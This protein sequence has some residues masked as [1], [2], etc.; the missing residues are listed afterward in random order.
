MASMKKALSVM[1]VGAVSLPPGELVLQSPASAQPVDRGDGSGGGGRTLR[2]RGPRTW[3]GVQ[4]RRREGGGR[5]RG[6]G[7]LAGPSRRS[8]RP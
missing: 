4:A 1:V 8:Q 7:R 2:D 3:Q 6:P 5:A